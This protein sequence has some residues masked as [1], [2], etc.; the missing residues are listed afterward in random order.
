MRKIAIAFGVAL[1][2]PMPAQAKTLYILQPRPSG[3]QQELWLNGKHAVQDVGAE[4]DVAVTQEHDALP[5]N[6]SA[7]RVYV[8]NKSAT[9]FNFGP[10]SVVV[11]LSDGTRIGML[12]SESLKQ[13]VERDTKR[14]LFFAGLGGALQ[15]GSANGYTT[16][17]FDYSGQMGGVHTSGSGT[18]SYNDPVAAQREQEAVRAQTD[19]NFRAFREQRESAM[20]TLGGLIQTSTV[21][22]GKIF[23]GIVAYDPPTTLKRAR[24][25]Q[26]VTIV[27]TAGATVHRI[28]ATIEGA[29]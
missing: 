16:G 8:M 5:G 9:A 3:S 24:G 19:A 1:A 18:F 21:L 7:F 6:P 11:E 14:R 28:A 29:D 4:A 12:T 23:G 15:A 25:P 22:P 27:V 2:A 20:Q 10:E 13:R 26:T 17:D